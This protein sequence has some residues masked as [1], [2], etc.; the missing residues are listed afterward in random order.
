MEDKI[1]SPDNL[2]NDKKIRNN[3]RSIVYKILSNIINSIVAFIPIIIFAGKLVF[4]LIPAFIILELIYT[5]LNWFN[6]YILL[7]E[8]EVRYCFGILSKTMI[9]IPRSNLKSMDISRGIVDKLLRYNAVKIESPSMNSE[10]KEIKMYLTIDDIESLKKFAF[11][12]SNV[13]LEKEEKTKAICNESSNEYIKIEEKSNEINIYRKVID[14]KTLFM[15]GLTSFNIVI[16][17]IGLAKGY[18]ILESVISKNRISSI[19][20]SVTP[21]YSNELNIFYA[22]FGI[23]ALIIILKIIAI[24]YN[25]IK[26]YNF[27]ISKENK[28]IKISYGLISNKEFS[29]NESSVKII[30]LKANVLR[31]LLKLYE[32]QVVVKGYSGNNDEKIILCPLGKEEDHIKILKDILPDWNIGLEKGEGMK[33]GK[34]IIV[35]KPIINIFIISIIAYIILRNKY[36]FLINL[37]IIFTIPYSILKGKNINLRIKNNK[38]RATNGGFFKKINILNKRDIQAVEFITTPFQKRYGLGKI[39]IHYYSE[40]GEEINL[41]FMENYLVDKLIKTK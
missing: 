7:K 8:D 20:S 32:M 24:A 1:I 31:Q 30:K 15:Y 3:I 21:E 40:I 38:I 22:I 33:R 5:Y 10:I 23:V 13:N 16:I 18:D 36:V 12:E 29:F 28:N 6:E 35:L 14:K 41:I 37:F 27:T 9:I 11:L 39:K 25:M 26:Y 34:F 17:F 2:N 19:I 4:I